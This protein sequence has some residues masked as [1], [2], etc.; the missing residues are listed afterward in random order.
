[1]IAFLAGNLISKLK[2]PATGKKLMVVADYFQPIL[3]V[4]LL[5]AIVD[6]GAPLDHHL[7]LGETIT[8]K[9]T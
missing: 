2:L 4:C 5:G 6:L 7:I 3:G 1:M 9:Q 8:K